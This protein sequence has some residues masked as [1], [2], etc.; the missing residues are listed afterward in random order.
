[1]SADI[2]K[3]VIDPPTVERIQESPLGVALPVEKKLVFKF[4]RTMSPASPTNLPD[5]TIITFRVPRVQGGGFS[6]A[7]FFETEDHRLAGK[8]RAAIGKG[9]RYVVESKA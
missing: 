6:P 3:A 2:A 9:L 7:G 4:V 8:I 1:M 5:G